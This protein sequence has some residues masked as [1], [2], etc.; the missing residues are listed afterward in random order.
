MN[1]CRGQT[2]RFA[3]ALHLTL[4]LGAALAVASPSPNPQPAKKVTALQI[5]TNVIKNGILNKKYAAKLATKGGRKPFTWLIT[6]GSLPAGL[7]LNSAT[8]QL[9]G[10]PTKAGVAAFTA[11]VTDGLGRKTAKDFKLAIISGPGQLQPDFNLSVAPQAV[12][13]RG[14]ATLAV[15]PA[16]GFS[17]FVNVAFEGLPGGMTAYPISPFSLPAGG[18]QL[19]FFSASSTPIGNYPI[20]V[21]A[22]SGALSHTATVTITVSGDQATPAPRSTYVRI[23]HRLP[24]DI[25]YDQAHKLVFASITELNQIDVISTVSGSRVASIRVPHPT[26][27]DLSVDNQRLYVAPGW[28]SATVGPEFLYVIDIETLQITERLPFYPPVIPSSPFHAFTIPRDVAVTSNGSILLVMGIKGSTGYGLFQW[29]PQTGE[30]VDRTGEAMGIYDPNFLGRSKDHSKVLISSDGSSGE[31]VLYDADT[32]SFTHSRTDFGEF[33]T[34]RPVAKP[35]GSQFAFTEGQKVI[36]LDGEFNEIKTFGCICNGMIYSNDGK[37]L[38][39]AESVFFFPALKV[40]DSE[41]FSVVGYVP[42]PPFYGSAEPTINVFPWDVDETGLIFGLSDRAV[43]IVDATAPT[44]LSNFGPGLGVLPHTGAVNQL[45]PVQ[46]GSSEASQ[47]PRVFFGSDEAIN[48]TLDNSTS[49]PSLRGFAPPSANPGPV[50]VTAVFPDGWMTIAPDAFTY[51]PHVLAVD[52]TGGPLEGGTRVDILGYGIRESGAQVTI[53]GRSATILEDNSVLISP[54]P[55][56]LSR[57]KILTPSGVSGPADLKITTPAGSTTVPRAFTYP[58]G[59][60]IAPIAGSFAKIVYDRSRK[61][62]YLSNTAANEVEVFSV[63]T[64]QFLAPIPTGILPLGMDLLPDG[65]KL[66][67]ANYGDKTVSVI[68]PDNPLATA[69]VLAVD[70]ADINS[71]RRPVG[72]AVTSAGKAFI[73]I[74]REGFSGCVGQLR[75]LD[76]SSM[77][78]TQ[79]TDTTIFCLTEDLLLT[80]SSPAKTKVLLGSRDSSGGEIAVWDASTDTFT[81]R[82]LGDFLFDVGATDGNGFG[83]LD[84]ALRQRSTVVDVEFPTELSAAAVAGQKVHPSGDLVYIPMNN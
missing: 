46:I 18:S 29:R 65:S 34:G 73:G 82:D 22:T 50:N 48:I 60:T 30:F 69:S 54:F 25:V 5:T 77:T 19:L 72:V 62:V 3:I 44:A 17:D 52:P 59:T 14:L 57:L 21:R 1:F 20:T 78:V 70:P 15:A 32:D 23:D 76:L 42:G 12:S 63:E 47:M 84:D 61:R 51:G 33:I 13:D 31:L 58:R 38:Y 16:N 8:G 79:R 56:P 75:Q 81:G 37:Y 11:S 74:T 53:G 10:L 6:S 41:T 27:F 36:I 7:T 43:S 55:Y 71:D 45:T 80:S 39:V 4:F 9:T 28:D 67:V 26:K 68:D 83:F 35:D 64:M 24:T 66:V 49:P 40:L 2:Y